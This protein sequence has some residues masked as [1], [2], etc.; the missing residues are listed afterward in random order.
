MA[1]L[2]ALAEVDSVAADLA[3]VAAGPVAAGDLAVEVQVAAGDFKI[4]V[5]AAELKHLEKVIHELEQKTS[6]EIRL[7]IVRASTFTCHV[8]YTLFGW[9]SGAAL[10]FMWIERHQLIWLAHWWWLPLILLCAGAGAWLLSRVPAVIRAVTPTSDLRGQCVERAEV[11]FYREGLGA[12][13]DQTGI[14]LFISMLEHQAVVLA[15]KG[16]DSKLAKGTW[17]EV[18]ATMLEGP[19]T[20]QWADR[21]EKALRQCGSVLAQHF[22]I[23]SGDRNELPNVVI[24]K[25]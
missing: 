3:A 15:D 4:P 21:L 9:L 23:Q 17:D 16:I 20:G 12:T 11:E 5:S 1:V 2:V 8:F 19:K 24:V 18:V 10:L 22:P 25:P 6:G 7:M 13:K 14:L